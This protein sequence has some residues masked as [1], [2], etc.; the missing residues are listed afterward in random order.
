MTYKVLY[1]LFLP[2]IFIICSQKKK[3]EWIPYILLCILMGIRYDSV[4]DYLPYVKIF[5]EIK[6]TGFP[7]SENIEVGWI[8]LNRM[9]SFIPYGWVL[10]SVH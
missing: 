3:W 7:D 1:L 4:S 6:R 8:Y 2:A 5:D 10:I 9:F